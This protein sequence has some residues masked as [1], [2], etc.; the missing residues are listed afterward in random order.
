MGAPVEGVA[1][2][3]LIPRGHK[4]ATRA[5]PAGEKVVKYNQIIGYAAGDIAPGD[6]V[7]TQNVA[8][9]ATDQEYEFGTDLRPVPLVSEAGRD[10]FMGFGAP[11]APWA[12]ATT[13][14]S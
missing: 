7:H 8:F 1:T 6:H 9:R 12:R 13:S 4:I 2:T 10:T 11:T 5:I 14:R 3:G